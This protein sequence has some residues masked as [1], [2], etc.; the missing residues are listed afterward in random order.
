MVLLST[1]GCCIYGTALQIAQDKGD[2][3][4]IRLLLE[5]GANANAAGEASG[6]I[7]AGIGSAIRG[8]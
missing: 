6:D 4:I 3:A 1:T 2:E 7:K 8:V 5:H